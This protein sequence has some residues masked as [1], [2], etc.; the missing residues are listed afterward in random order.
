MRPQDEEKRRESER[1]KKLQIDQLRAD[2]RWLMSSPAGRR[3]VWG[4]LERA[5]VY[6]TSFNEA[7]LTMAFREGERNMGLVLQGQVLSHCPEDFMRMLAEG[8]PGSGAHT[9]SDAA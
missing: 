3:L 9:E 4:W 1:A 7:A 5:G 6:R 2:T 8:P